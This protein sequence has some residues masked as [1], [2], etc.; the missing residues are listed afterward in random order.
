MKSWFVLLSPAS[1][2]G[3]LRYD[4]INAVFFSSAIVEPMR[5][6]VRMEVI[7]IFGVR[8]DLRCRIGRKC[9]RHI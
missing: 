2:E 5:P 4:G 9:P 6:M 3:V 8:V 1:L 7:F